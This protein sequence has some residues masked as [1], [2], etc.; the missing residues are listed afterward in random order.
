MAKI[1]MVQTIPGCMNGI[2]AKKYIKGQEYQIDGVQINQRLAD[3]FIGCKAAKIV[4]ERKSIARAPEQAVIEAAPENKEEKIEP[5]KAQMSVSEAK[6]LASDSEPE[7]EKEDENKLEETK[8]ADGSKPEGDNINPDAKDTRVYQLADELKVNWQDV[9]KAANKLGI[10]VK[11]AQAGLTA[12]EVQR[13][14]ERF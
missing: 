6:R 3:M 4:R 1:I 8:D 12:I 13:I 9:I 11:A 2:T 7:D 10:E 14:K 5:E